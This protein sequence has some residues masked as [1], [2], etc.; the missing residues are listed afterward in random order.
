MNARDRGNLE[1][2]LNAD[3]KTMAEWYKTATEDDMEY[4]N[5]LLRTAR[6]ELELKLL[7]TLD[8]EAEDDLS[9]AQAVLARFAL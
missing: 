9:D 4:A 3:K 1:F 5:E 8:S 2:L 6:T 7:E